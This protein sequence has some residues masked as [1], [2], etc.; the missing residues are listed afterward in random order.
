M[1]TSAQRSWIAKDSDRDQNI[2]HPADLVLTTIKQFLLGPNPN[3]TPRQFPSHLEQ[4][5]T[6]FDT[7]YVSKERLNVLLQFK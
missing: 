6:G 3:A 2:A 4:V 1:L 5:L 7:D